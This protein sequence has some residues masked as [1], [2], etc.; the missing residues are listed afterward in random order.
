MLLASTTT[1]NTTRQLVNVLIWWLADSRRLPNKEKEKEIA[2][3]LIGDEDRQATRMFSK[4][5]ML[6]SLAFV[7]ASGHNQDDHHLHESQI[8]PPAQQPSHE[9][10]LALLGEVFD[11]ADK[12]GDKLVTADELKAWLLKLHSSIIKEN[13]DQQWT[14]YSPEEREVHS[15]ETYEPERQQTISW[16]QYVNLTFPEEVLAAVRANPNQP[17]EKVAGDEDLSNYWVMYH[18]SVKR[19]QAADKNRD[20]V[21]VKE[22]FVNFLH[23]EESSETKHLMVEEALDD[24]DTDKNGEVTFQEYFKHMSDVSSDEEKADANEFNQVCL[25]LAIYVFE[26]LIIVLICRTNSLNSRPIS[27]AIRMACST[28]RS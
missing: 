8:P 1:N 27:I 12:D 16:D 13:V 6:L 21:L 7:L 25:F 5:F 26:I 14:Y 23:P 4:V 19:W 24:M 11:L 22:E 10:I 2:Y 20:E 28:R 3:L 15:W 17:D 18:R 9:N